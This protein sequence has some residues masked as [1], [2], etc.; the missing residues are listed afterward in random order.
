MP[1][2]TGTIGWKSIGLTEKDTRDIVMNVSMVLS[3]MDQFQ[4]V[5]VDMWMQ[6][7]TIGLFSTF[8]AFIPSLMAKLRRLQRLS[9]G[10]LLTAPC[11]EVAGTVVQSS[12]ALLLDQ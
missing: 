3:D 2:W 1:S 8:H 7:M 6:A 4:L 12:I 9:V 11:A 5:E 10:L